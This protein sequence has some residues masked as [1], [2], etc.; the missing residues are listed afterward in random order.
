MIAVVFPGTLLPLCTEQCTQL[1]QALGEC[2]SVMEAQ[3]L[4]PSI[5][6]G[7]LT[8]LMELLQFAVELNCTQSDSLP[9]PLATVDREECVSLNIY[10]EF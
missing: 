4:M 3:I 10:C 6:S 7:T 2:Y 8:P 1:Q 5:A 9:L